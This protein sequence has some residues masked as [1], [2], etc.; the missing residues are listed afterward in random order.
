MGG[1]MDGWTRKKEE[2][3]EEREQLKGERGGEV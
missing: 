1:W 3:D 2:E